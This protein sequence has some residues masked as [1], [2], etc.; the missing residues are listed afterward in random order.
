MSTYVISEHFIQPLSKGKRFLESLGFAKGL[1]QADVAAV[2]S[3]ARVRGVALGFQPAPTRKKNPFSTEQVIQLERLAFHGEG[4]EAVFAGY[5]CFLIHT[6]L[7]WSDGQHCIQEPT[8]DLEG[9]RGFLEAAL[10]HHKTSKKRRT[11]V[12]RLLPVAGVLPGLSGLNWAAEWLRKR[13]VL[14][15]RAS[16][17]QP[18][19]PAPL[20]GGGWT[21]QPLTS[22]EASTRLR[23]I[24][25]AWNPA[26]VRNVATHS[27]KATI[28]SWMSKSNLSLA[29]RRLAWIPC[30]T[31]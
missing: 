6:R 23:E 2:L 20:A 8:L 18:T 13:S 28:L 7:R 15:L 1:L 26:T 14:G 31:W 22:T 11:N 19:M 3:S 5:I 10:Y 9:G 21:C 30:H 24:L 4:Q 29:M 12:I 16:M 17:K 27:A 25:G